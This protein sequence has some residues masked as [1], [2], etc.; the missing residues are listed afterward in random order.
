MRDEYRSELE[1]LRW[2]PEGR[3]ALVRSLTAGAGRQRR[4]RRPL[5][6]A[7][8]FAAAACALTLSV[9]AAVVR[10]PVL[11]QYFGGGAGYRQSSALVGK[12][13]TANGW[14]MTLTDCA[15]D[16]RYLCLGF[17]LEAP[18]GT[19]LGPDWAAADPDEDFDFPDS[20]GGYAW[21]WR[22]PE[23]PDP[24]DNR[25]GYVLWI[26]YMPREPG[27]DGLNGRDMTLRIDGVGYIRILPDGTRED[28]VLCGET[29]D[30]GTLAVAYP[31]RTLRLEPRLPVT[32]R[33]VPA[34][35][36]RL[37]VSPVGVNVWLEGE[38]LRNH[39]AFWGNYGLCIDLPEI[40]LYDRDGNLLEPDPYTP[41]GIRGGSG[42]NAGED[43]DSPPCIHVNQS[44]GYLLD[45]DS[46]DRVEIC[47]VS[48][49]LHGGEA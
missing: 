25:L 14:T 2:T 46:L 36:T 19:V 44:Y 9:G 7:A 30:F 12:A 13:V 21:Q 45:M 33:E 31:D 43:P 8:L 37:E 10:L 24:T 32:I 1:R 38:A 29:W 5:R 18:E 6:T 27:T 4:A 11:E 28:V 22:C 48:I 3:A 20:R 49:P 40:A 47:G 15:G 42:C 39:H 41:F 23:D 35:L 26:E 16:D 34:R 17:E